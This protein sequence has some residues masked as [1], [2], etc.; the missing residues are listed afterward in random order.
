MST[1]TAPV[2]SGPQIREFLSDSR[3]YSPAQMEAAKQAQAAFHT[4]RPGRGWHCIV[5]SCM[6]PSIGE[7]PDGTQIWICGQC[8]R[9]ASFTSEE[10]QIEIDVKRKTA[11]RE[12]EKEKARRAKAPPPT[13]PRTALADSILDLEATAASITAL[14]SGLST[15]NARVADAQTLVDSAAYALRMAEEQEVEHSVAIAIGAT[16]GKAKAPLAAAARSTLMDA[17]ASLELARTTF[18]TIDGRLSAA[19]AHLSAAQGRVQTAALNVLRHEAPATAASIVERIEE[20]WATVPLLQWLV[21]MRAAIDV[22]P[23][24]PAWTLLGNLAEGRADSSVDVWKSALAKLQKDPDAKL[25]TS[26]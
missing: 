1:K 21:S 6:M 19:E 18:R 12:S 11:E 2:M 3:R 7:K 10:W 8:K 22:K 20:V 14:Q 24:S 13:A 9:P 16:N 5:D 23:H 26:V 25:P 4:S 17:Q 15:S